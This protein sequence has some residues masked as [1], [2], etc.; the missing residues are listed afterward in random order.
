M[1][2]QRFGLLLSKPCRL[3][4]LGLPL[5]LLIFKLILKYLLF[6]DPQLQRHP[7]NLNQQPESEVVLENGLQIEFVD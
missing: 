1:S 3:L 2:L 7:G 4:Y 5:L 6:G